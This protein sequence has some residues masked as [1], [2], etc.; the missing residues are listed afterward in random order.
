MAP[1]YAMRPQ[2]LICPCNTCHS[3]ELPSVDTNRFL[4]FSPVALFIP[5][6]LYAST[7]CSVLLDYCDRLYTRMYF[8]VLLCTTVIYYILQCTSV[9]NFVLQYMW[10][11]GTL[12]V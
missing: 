11:H 1:G 7:N 2:D 6:S 5:L 10:D 4:S 8:C 3:I 12:G 9:Y